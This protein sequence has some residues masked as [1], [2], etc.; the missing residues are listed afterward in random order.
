MSKEKHIW[1]AIGFLTLVCICII[2]TCPLLSP[3]M[4]AVTD[5]HSDSRPGNEDTCWTVVPNEWIQLTV[6]GDPNYYSIMVGYRKD[7]YV[8]WKCGPARP[9]QDPNR[10]IEDEAINANSQGEP[11]RAGPL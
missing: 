11:Q 5:A 3:W 10:T 6:T 9:V 4:A 7:G 8:V 1:F 2:L